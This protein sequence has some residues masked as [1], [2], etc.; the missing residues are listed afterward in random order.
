M[1]ETFVFSGILKYGLIQY[2]TSNNKF[3]IC[4]PYADVDLQIAHV[5]SDLAWGSTSQ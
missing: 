4:D 5:D 1:L 2:N 3:K